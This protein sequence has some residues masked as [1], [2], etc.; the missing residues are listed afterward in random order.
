MIQ[1]YA[2]GG[3]YAASYAK[4]VGADIAGCPAGK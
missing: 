1:V 4:F 3:T 2:G